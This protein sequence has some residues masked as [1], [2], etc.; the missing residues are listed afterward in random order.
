VA[1]GRTGLSSA[2]KSWPV[3]DSSRGNQLFP[4]RGPS[5]RG[6]PPP[7]LQSERDFATFVLC[8]WR[9]KSEADGEPK[10][11]V[12]NHH[13]VIFDEGGHPRPESLRRRFARFHRSANRVLTESAEKSAGGRHAATTS[14]AS[15]TVNNSCRDTPARRK[16]EPG[17]GTESGCRSYPRPLFAA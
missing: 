4:W 12:P 1:W 17:G 13:S 5:R 11:V 10:Y 7:T 3:R 8:P 2:V 6:A 15:S 16:D 9:I 14:D